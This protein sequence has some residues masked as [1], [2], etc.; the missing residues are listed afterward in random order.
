MPHQ[1]QFA[2]WVS[3]PVPQVFAFFANPENLPRL[4][5]PAAE[6]KIEG[7]QLVPPPPIPDLNA[8][9]L[10]HLAGVGSVIDT[11]F[12]PIRFLKWR[13]KW[14]AAITEFEWNHHFADVQQKGPF[15]R[16]HHRHEFM[17]NA[18]NGF[19]GTLVRDVIEY[20]VGFGR[21]GELANSLF[22]ERQ[23]RQ[24]FTARQK[25]LPKLLSEK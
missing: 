17:P 4:M 10:H 14:T 21:L 8:I 13:R 9:A 18:R 2:D 15:K 12:R 6:T 25:I 11:T 19:N 7:Y 3:F 23:M 20:E 16:W 5:P 22:I 24:T 1:L